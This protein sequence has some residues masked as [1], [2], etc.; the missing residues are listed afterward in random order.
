[1]IP[2]RFQWALMIDITNNCH[3]SCSNCTRMLNHRTKETAFFMSPEIFQTAVRAV[4]D[5]PRDSDPCVGIHSG[6]RKVVGLIG[7]EPLLHPQFPDLVDIM[8][9]EIPH[10]I[11]RGLWTSKDWMTGEHPVWGK[12]RPMVERLIGKR[13]THDAS[14]PSE[15]HFCGYINWN[16]HLPEMHVHHQPVLVA[17]KD[18]I[19]DPVSRWQLISQ[20]WVQEQWSA[21]ITPKGFF[22]C[23]VAGAR[24]MIFNGPGGLPLTPGVWRGDLGFTSQEGRLAPTGPYAQQ[25]NN[26]CESCGACVP[27]AGR[28]DSENRDDIS[29]SNVIPLLSLRSPRALRG[30]LVIHE[31][32]TYDSR[33]RDGWRPMQYVKSAPPMNQSRVAHGQS[34]EET[35]AKRL[36][37]V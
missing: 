16:M 18:I 10:V 3:L 23:E 6:R 27:L 22:F 25:I 13:P 37:T 8:V 31:P 7:G 2:P 14:G 21:T 15:K 17:S 34:D 24:D 5:F 35:S 36:D 26:A 4:K 9:A 20:C 33:A 11:Y 32:G 12:Y 29:R 19:E 28:L 30:D 1:M